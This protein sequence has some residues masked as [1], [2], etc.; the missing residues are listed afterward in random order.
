MSNLSEIAKLINSK[1]PELRKKALIQLI[2]T[3]NWHKH[4]DLIS[5]LLDDPEKSIKLKTLDE[6]TKAHA[7]NFVGEMRHL[8]TDKDQDVRVASI[9]ALLQFNSK[10]NIATFIQSLPSLPQELSQEVNKQISTFILNIE[11]EPE[12]SEAVILQVLDNIASVNPDVRK[13]AMLY[14][15][16]ISNK[17]LAASSFITFCSK[18][19]DLILDVLFNEAKKEANFFNP[20]LEVI[21]NNVQSE[22]D[23]IMAIKIAFFLKH[24]SLVS[25][26]T[27]ELSNEN[28]L[29][30]RNAVQKL[31]ELNN[32]DSIPELI[33]LLD[34]KEISMV[35]IETLGK[36]KEPSL[37]KD[38]LPRLMKVGKSEQIAI[39]ESVE[40]IAGTDPR[41]IPS[42]VKF[43]G[44]EMTIYEVKKQISELVI[45]ICKKTNSPIPQEIK[46]I[47]D[48]EEQKLLDKLPDLKLKMDDGL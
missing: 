17:N 26:L 38:L 25:M 3:E 32:K 30:R 7:K 28:W 45:R 10:K 8:C 33:K 39:L 6:L 11:S 18:V 31:G 2:S 23:R 40:N 46:Q 37:L 9:K 27:T 13:V 44:S 1:E 29:I 47:L 43:M 20:L 19:S 42:L 35:V 14:L 12:T 24:P 21:L 34:D 15:K 41:L 22:Q 16:Q 4:T 5:I 36:F 48:G